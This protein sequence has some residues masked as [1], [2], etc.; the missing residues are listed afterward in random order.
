[1]S[2]KTLLVLGI[3]WIMISFF[4]IQ[5][6]YAKYISGFTTNTNVGI[7][8]WDLALNNSN[9]INQSDFSQHLTLVFPGSE[10]YNANCVVPGAIGYFDLTVDSS[11]VTLPFKYTVT[12]SFSA[13]N[14]IQDMEIIG[15]SLNGDNTNITYLDN[16][17]T[18]ASNTVLATDN[19]SSM[20]I[21]VQWVDGGQ[22]EA[23]N[24]IADTEVAKID[25]KTVIV[26]NVSF[27]QMQ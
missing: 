24:D 19:S 10:Y 23:L 2:K 18:E 7:S 4:I 26:A 21:Y 16:I 6:T 1:M 5:Y 14:S 12:T 8:N 15:F 9:I 3:L 17:V 20:R 22:N 27:D 13:G 11:N 25:G